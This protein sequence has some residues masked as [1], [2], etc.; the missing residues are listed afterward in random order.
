MAERRHIF[1]VTNA[2]RDNCGPS[3]AGGKANRFIQTL[4]NF[5]NACLRLL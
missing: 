4:K 3:S 2:P 5:V 1:C